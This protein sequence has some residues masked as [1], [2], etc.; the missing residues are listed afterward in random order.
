MKKFKFLS[1]LLNK[2][3][4]GL[5]VVLV[6]MV[7][8]MGLG[9]KI[10]NA[11]AAK[12]A[13]PGITDTFWGTC[14]TGD[15]KKNNGVIAETP[16]EGCA[17]NYNFTYG[18]GTSPS[19]YS[20]KCPT[21]KSVVC[22][23]NAYSPKNVAIGVNDDNLIAAPTKPHSFFC[24]KKSGTSCNSSKECEAGGVC[25]NGMCEA[26]IGAGTVSGLFGNE[27]TDIRDTIRMFINI[28]LGFLGVLTVLF[29][30]YGGILWL[31]A[32]GNEE[33][34]T[35]GKNTLMWAAIGAIV[36]SIAWTISSYVLQIGKTVG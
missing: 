20:I 32:A 34:V 24:L 15:T 18:A 6:G 33:K 21:D 10:H 35:K 30:I 1:W 12:A 9:V 26:D 13:I 23:Q 14:T 22:S 25:E 27:I 4:W 29:I 3:G 36:I 2:K 5:M 28:G 17:C 31:T 8:V 11:F 7:V 19:T 16:P